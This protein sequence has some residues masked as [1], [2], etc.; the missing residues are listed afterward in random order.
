M[1]S[2]DSSTEQNGADLTFSLPK[3]RCIRCGH[4]W[5]PRTEKLPRVCPKCKSPYWDR[6]RVLKKAVEKVNPSV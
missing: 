4:T 1:I 6:P 2:I 3:L 5:P